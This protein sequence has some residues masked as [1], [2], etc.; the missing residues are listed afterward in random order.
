MK[1]AEIRS[2]ITDK[3]EVEKLLWYI[4][5]NWGEELE[6]MP[7]YSAHKNEI[8]DILEEWAGNEFQK[9]WDYLRE[10]RMGELISHIQMR[11]EF[12]GFCTK[13][14][15]SHDRLKSKLLRECPWREVRPDNEQGEQWERHR[16]IQPIWGSM[17]QGG[18]LSK[19]M[20]Q[21]KTPEQVSNDTNEK[22]PVS[23][24]DI[25]DIF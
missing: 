20:S 12:V 23:F 11:T 3:K 21:D 19:L 17:I 14:G 16:L 4:V 10:T 8:K 13:N 22:V 1:G 25:E 24:K 9:F 18:W 6:K 2:I 5:L 7:V 15:Y